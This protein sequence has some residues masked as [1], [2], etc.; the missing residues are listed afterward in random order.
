MHPTIIFSI[1][2]NGPN[3]VSVKG[4]SAADRCFMV[5]TLQGWPFAQ[6]WQ[7]DKNCWMLKVGLA[8]GFGDGG[9]AKLQV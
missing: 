8:A 2:E 5:L 1:A 7:D 9:G 4:N 6:D 3:C